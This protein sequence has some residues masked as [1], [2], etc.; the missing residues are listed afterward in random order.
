MAPPPPLRA[1]RREADPTPLSPLR[2]PARSVGA[3]S[4]RLRSNMA[5]APA[6]LPSPSLPPSN[7]GAAAAA[8][9][10]EAARGMLGGRGRTLA[11]LGRPRA[12]PDF[13]AASIH[14]PGGSWLAW[15]KES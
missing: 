8:A 7:R 12:A 1:A 11:R 14:C 6:P 10:A 4:S 5:A 13:S 9:A 15:C 3:Y 2:T